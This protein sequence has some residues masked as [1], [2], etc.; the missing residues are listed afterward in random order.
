MCLYVCQ[1]QPHFYGYFITLKIHVQNRETEHLLV[2]AC[3]IV[4]SKASM[5]AACVIRPDL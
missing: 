5:Y 3:S 1:V 4:G 2:L